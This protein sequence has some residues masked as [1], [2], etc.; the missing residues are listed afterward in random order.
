MEVTN[1]KDI[2]GNDISNI[3]LNVDGTVWA[4]LEIDGVSSTS[5]LSA[6]CC[7]DNLYTFDPKDA[8][9]Y[10]SSSCDTGGSYKIIL[11]P[12]GNSGALFQVDEN[13]KDICTLEVEFDYLLKLNCDS[14]TQ[15]LEAFV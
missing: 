10:W 5:K 1:C 11:D 4:V 2:N 6:Q 9:C 14:L 15:S 8:K 13:Q 7:E 12:E 3:Q